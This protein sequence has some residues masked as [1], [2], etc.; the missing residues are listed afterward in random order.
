VVESCEHGNESLGSIKGRSFLDQLNDCQLLKTPL[1]VARVKFG[2]SAQVKN[3]W[4]VF[5][6]RVLRRMFGPKGE[7]VARKQGEF[8]K[9]EF[10]NLYSSPSSMGDE[11]CILNF[12]QKT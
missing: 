10:H 12:S 8:H 11:K 7:E 9:K 2:S 3:K 1:Y 5:E 4:R 6:N